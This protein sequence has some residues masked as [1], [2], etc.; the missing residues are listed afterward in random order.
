MIQDLHWVTGIAAVADAFASTV[1]SDVINVRGEGIL[2][3]LHNGVG[4]TGTSTLTVEACDD[5]TPTTTVAVEFIYRTN[6][7]S[8]TWSAWTKATTAGFTTTAGSNH[9]YQIYCTAQQLAS[10]GTTGYGY[11]RLKA[12]EVVDSPVLGGIL[13]AVVNPRH[14]PVGTSQID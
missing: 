1:S 6:T 4:V 2:F 3:V 13:A 5:V 10:E 9:I 8:D 11:A 12:V 7:A 14:A